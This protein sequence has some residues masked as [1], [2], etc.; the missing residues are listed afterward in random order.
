[1]EKMPLLV[2]TWN[3]LYACIMT[4]WTNMFD[5]KNYKNKDNSINYENRDIHGMYT[6]C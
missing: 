1:M 6:K 3:L 4:Q 2:K 5:K